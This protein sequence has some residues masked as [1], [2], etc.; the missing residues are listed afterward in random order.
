MIDKKGETKFNSQ[1]I[2]EI[3]RGS[4]MHARDL[5][6]LNLTSTEMSEKKMSR[7]RVVRPSSA[8]LPRDDDILVSLKKH[9]NIYT[10]GLSYRT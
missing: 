7:L 9:F 2:G 10:K 6:S 3:L 5:F 8:I 4:S 1:T